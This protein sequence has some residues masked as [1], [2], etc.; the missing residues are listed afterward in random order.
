MKIIKETTFH[1]YTIESSDKSARLFI[2]VEELIILR[3]KINKILKEE[4]RFYDNG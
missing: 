4:G 1:G 2:S 3:D